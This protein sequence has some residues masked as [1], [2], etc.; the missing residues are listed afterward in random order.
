MRAVLH[1]FWA[2]KAG[3]SEDEYEDAFAPN[4][5]EVF[6][7]ERLRFAVAD[8]ATEASY[9]GRWA[10]LLVQGYRKGWLGVA[11]P[12]QALQRLARIWRRGLQTRKLPWYAQEKLRHGAFAALLGL[13]LS[14]ENAA[15][16]DG[17][18][19]AYSVGDCC[20]FH[21]AGDRLLTSFPFDDPRDF[22]SRPVLLSSVAERNGAAGL[23]NVLAQPLEIVAREVVHQPRSAAR[24]RAVGHDAVESQNLLLHS[25]RMKVINPHRLVDEEGVEA[26]RCLTI[27]HGCREENREAQHTA[28]TPNGGG[29]H[30]CILVPFQLKTPMYDI[31]ILHSATDGR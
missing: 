13:E 29:F 19:N 24:P 3:N 11:D 9:S 23:G 16:Q 21:V 6:T 27:R 12:S 26:R 8:G 7:G 17:A 10:R 4:A 31:A 25:A 2:P 5:D 14:T 1:T 30:G 28:R 20:L 15:D 18:W 22:G